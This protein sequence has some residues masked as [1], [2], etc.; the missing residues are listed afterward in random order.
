MNKNV[1]IAI[2]LT[3][4]SKKYEIYH[5]KPTLVE[6]FVKGNN[7]T[8]W[9]LK[10]VNLTIKQG[11][12]IGIIGLNG[13]GKTT[14]LKLMAGIT[15]PTTGTIQ[16]FGRVVSLIEL[17]AGFHSDLTGFQNIYIN[18][19]LLGLQ[20]KEIDS[21][22]SDIIAFADLKQFIDAPLF[23][24]SNGMA[25][26]LGFSIAVHADPDILLLDE[27]LSAGDSNFQKKSRN[28]LKEFFRKEKTIIVVTHHLDFVAATCQRILHIQNG[29][30]IH[31]G[32]KKV[33][34]QYDKN[35][36]QSY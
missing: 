29:S 11:E 3:S 21:K 15:I 35:W 30:L 24:Y 1:P 4:V 10:N 18:A 7:E 12:K 6:K 27:N 17:G 34:T 9:A 33:L 13:S 32:G 22:L 20:K 14:L 2:Q 26:R 16:T 28:K 23:T 31:D 5:E 19:M 25:L 36:R 8:F